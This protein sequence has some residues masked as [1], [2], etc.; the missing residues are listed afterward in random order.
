MALLLF[1]G[2]GQSVKIGEDI[3]VTV[4]AVKSAKGRDGQLIIQLAFDAPRD[5]K[6]LRAEL[7]ERPPADRGR[8]DD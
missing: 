6:I 3:R 2:L 4:N 8:A 1:R 7:E 5:V